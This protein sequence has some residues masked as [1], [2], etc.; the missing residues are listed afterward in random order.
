MLKLMVRIVLYIALSVL[1]ITTKKARYA[2]LRRYIAGKGGTVRVDS[3]TAE[4]WGIKDVIISGWAGPSYGRYKKILVHSTTLY[5]GRGFWGRPE[6]MYIVGCFTAA[7]DSKTG[8]AVVKDVYD[9][10]P[11][12]DGEYYVSP[13]PLPIAGLLAEVPSK[14]LPQVFGLNFDGRLGISNRFWEGLGKPFLTV[15]EVELPAGLHY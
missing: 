1:Y 14:L 11:R 5:E 9:W 15:V 7:Y 2:F 8:R 3:L 13:L 10:H 4:K 12:D 6:G